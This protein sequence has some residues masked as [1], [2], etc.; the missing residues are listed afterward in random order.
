M[1]NIED[2]VKDLE[3]FKSELNFPNLSPP[4]NL[5][6]ILNSLSSFS[7]I[8]TL[9]PE[10]LSE[11]SVLLASYSLFLH[12]EENRYKAYA[13]WCEH[14]IKRIIGENLNQVPIEIGNYY[15]NVEIYIRSNHAKARELDTKKSFALTRLEIIKGVSLK[16]DKMCDTL[17]GLS[18]A[19]RSGQYNKFT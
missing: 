3:I 17:K 12:I 19:K 13:D 14:N 6:E 16:L 2:Y 11:Y 1:S 15:Q 18:Y 4:S 8:K 7:I 5:N 9:S 10:M